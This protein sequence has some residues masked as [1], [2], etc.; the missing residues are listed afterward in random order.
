MHDHILKKHEQSNHTKTP[1]EGYDTAEQR[2]KVS[3]YDKVRKCCSGHS[4]KESLCHVSKELCGHCPKSPSSIVQCSMNSFGHN[5]NNQTTHRQCAT[6]VWINSTE[7]QTGIPK[8]ILA[9]VIERMSAHNNETF[10]K[11]S[12]VQLTTTS[13]QRLSNKRTHN[14][15]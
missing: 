9:G 7:S 10:S 1:G 5:L 8:W 6:P 4:I 11:C 15:Q 3:L 13:T 14:M 12:I 2:R